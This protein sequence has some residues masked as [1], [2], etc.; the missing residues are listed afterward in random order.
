MFIS[1]ICIVLLGVAGVF[2][3]KT[4]PDLFLFDL[5]KEVFGE[6]NRGTYSGKD[7]KSEK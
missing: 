2:L 1:L 7:K 4:K 6:N 5:M 3:V